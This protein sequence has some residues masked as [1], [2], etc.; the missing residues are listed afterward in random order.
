MGTCSHNG[1]AGPGPRE[2]DRVAI[3][4]RRDPDREPG[5]VGLDHESAADDKAHV[6]RR[7]RAA[8]SAGEEHEVARLR[9][10]KIDP[11]SP[12]PLLLRGSRNV[13]ACRLV[14]HHDQPRAIERVW[15]RAAP[16]IGL[17]E[18]LL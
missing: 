10:M 14:G 7:L 17:S 8:I 13:D 11:R 16:L 3:A 18:L 1:C 12:L 5:G 9:L 6:A 2:A 4:V 15:P